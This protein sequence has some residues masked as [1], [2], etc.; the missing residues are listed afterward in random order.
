MNEEI[1][2]TKRQLAGVNTQLQ[3]I[4]KRL[5]SNKKK[6]DQAQVDLQQ[7]NHRLRLLGKRKKTMEKDLQNVLEDEKQQ[8]EYLSTLQETL[9]SVEAQLEEKQSELQENNKRALQMSGDDRAEYERLKAQARQ[10]SIAFQKLL[11]DI[12]S[13]HQLSRSQQASL[14]S[15]IA[16]LQAD[17]LNQ[18]TMIKEYEQRSA[19]LSTLTQQYEQ[20]ITRLETQKSAQLSSTQKIEGQIEVV[21]QELAVVEQKLNYLGYEKSKFKLNTKLQESIE[22]MKSLFGEG[23]GI[24]GKLVNLVKPIQKKYHLAVQVAMQKHLDSIV[25]ATKDI[26]TQCIVYLKENHIGSATFLP[27]DSLDVADSS[28]LARLRDSLPSS[29]RYKLAIDVLEVEP[30]YRRAAVFAMGTTVIADNLEDARNLA[31]NRRL[32]G[33]DG[34]QVKVVTLK[35]QI[36]SKAGAMTGGQAQELQRDRFQEAEVIALQSQKA[37]LEQQKRELQQQLEGHVLGG[38]AVGVPGGGGGVRSHAAYYDQ[39]IRSLQAKMHFNQT[40]LSVLREKISHLS[41]QLAWK[42]SHLKDL[43]DRKADCDN[44]CKEESTAI[45]ETA[46][47]IASNQSALFRNLSQRLQIED[48]VTW[49]RETESQK[50]ILSAQ[51]EVLTSQVATLKSQIAYENNKNFTRSRQ[52][53]TQQLAQTE[54]SMETVSNEVK[55]LQN[56][57][58]SLV[59][60]TQ[61]DLKTQLTT[62]KQDREVLFNVL[63]EMMK[64]KEEQHKHIEKV[65]KDINR[66]ELVLE[67]IR[68]DLHTTLV[69]AQLDQIPLPWG[70]RRRGKTQQGEE[71]EMEVEGEMEMEGPVGVSSRETE[72]SVHFSDINDPVVRR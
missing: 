64:K 24:Y 9:R 53:L 1:A 25:V 6:A 35:G 65:K 20:E 69:N 71:E 28:V 67:K 19:R 72:P 41:E 55:T 68:H 13:R 12:Q 36:I 15:Q 7:A 63:D 21:D 32:A 54:D 26:A 45:E 44:Q 51:I 40:D 61:K 4:E 2:D 57:F 66:C 62:L 8:Q 42:G 17:I 39:S 23:V 10:E 31:F 14:E 30:L 56:R 47:K 38:E 52:R 50:A 60:N 37:A 46:Q 70:R 43:Q 59:E 29:Q 18:S 49:E 11:D 58:Q 33:V 16:S 34:G 3:T 5:T 48:I 27:L 22:V